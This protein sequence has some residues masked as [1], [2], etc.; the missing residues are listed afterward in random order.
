MLAISTRNI[1]SFVII[2]ILTFVVI[3]IL[4][5]TSSDKN[6]I[7]NNTKPFVVKTEKVVL[8]SIRP[9]YLFYGN[10]RAKS[11]VDLIARLS[12][13]IIKTSSK[14][15]TN[16]YFEKEETIFELDPFNYKQE[17]IK[18]ES[19]LKELISE[20]KTMNLIYTEVKQQ[21]E[22]SKKDF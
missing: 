8:K 9:E 5:L 13:K 10:V 12:G 17:L 3:I 4:K 15:L 19:K 14:V 1:K 21:Q 2:L 18:K 16:E 20:L 22:L 11:E 6:L 7:E